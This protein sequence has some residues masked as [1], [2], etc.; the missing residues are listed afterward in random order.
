MAIILPQARPAIQIANGTFGQFTEPW[1]EL[2]KSRAVIEDAIG[3]VGRLETSDKTYPFLSTAFLVAESV[4]LTTRHVVETFAVG[5]GDKQLRF[6]DDRK[7]WINFK[8]EKDEDESDC[9]AVT[10]ILFIHP[11]WDVAALRIEAQRPYLSLQTYP[12]EKD[13]TVVAVGYPAFDMRNDADLQNRIFAGVFNRKTL[14]PA[15]IH[16]ETML[17]SYGRSVRTISHDASTLGGTT[18]APLINV[19][20]GDVVGVHF[21]GKY[22]RGN[23][24]VPAWELMRDSR[25]RRHLNLPEPDWMSDWDQSPAVSQSP[26]VPAFEPND[27]LFKTYSYLS[28]ENLLELCGLLLIGFPDDEKIAVLFRGIPPELV[29]ALPCGAN[30][31]EKLLSRLIELNR[32]GPVGDHSPLYRLL[33]TA[34]Y[35]RDLFPEH[36]RL[37]ALFRLVAGN[38][39][40]G[41]T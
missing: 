12:P 31:K 4:I 2:E 19:T 8:A 16:G 23:S 13:T 30:P 36:A 1:L 15:R 18:G 32:L 25:V 5:I 41:S 29:A 6:R 35:L 28:F 38:E 22:L 39:F 3:C 40:A 9:A 14:M 33:Q 26:L 37:L 17:D 34:C 20:S 27:N 24:A 10:Q 7:V 21:A 11:Y